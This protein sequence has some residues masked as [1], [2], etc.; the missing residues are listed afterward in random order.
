MQ[1]PVDVTALP[2]PAQRLLDPKSPAPLRQMAAKGIAPGLKPHEAVTVVAI[3][4]EA[5]DPIA[6]AARATLAALPGP[7]IAGALGPELP[8]GVL[9]AMAPHYAKNAG[10]MEKLLQLPQLLPDTVADIAAVCNEQVA[11]LVATNEEKLLKH[12]SIIEKLYMNKATRMSTSDRILELAVRNDLKLE[13]IPAFDEAA[14]EIRGQLIPEPSEEPTYDDVLFNETEKIAQEIPLDPTKE[15]THR[16][17]EETGEEVIEPK[18]QSVETKLKDMTMTQK[19]RRA[20]LGTPSER[21]ILVRDTNRNVARAAIKSPLI[22][23]NEVVRIAASRN[24]SDEVLGFI[25]R[26]R[27]WTRSY[28]VK[29]N[30]VQNPRTPFGFVTKLIPHLFEHDLKALAKSKN[31]TGSV[32]QA[33]RQQLHRKGK[34]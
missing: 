11:E 7:V 32:S 17:D 27:D 31:V 6:E 29:I 19:I 14:A 24:V 28:Q 21:A 22:Q 30:L 33:A 2:A 3:L 5:D 13:G 4:A 18:F 16:I 10:V 12:P 26:S 23:E 20:M 25:A 8:P 9:A 15:S 1:P 34:M